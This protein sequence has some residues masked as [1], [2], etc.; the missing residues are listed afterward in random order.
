[1]VFTSLSHDIVAHEV[2]HALL[3]GLRADFDV[4]SGQDVRA[5]HEGFADLVAIFQRFSYT[6]V[7]AAAIDK[8]RGRLEDAE[9][10]TALARQFGQTTGAGRAL[11]SAMES[12]SEARAP[13]TYHEDLEPHQLGLVLVLAIFDAFRTVFRRKTARYF[14]LASNG[15]GEL[16]TGALSPDL[17]AILAEKASQLASQFLNICI[18]AIDY[19]P[20]VDI[21]LGEFL[22]A[23][24]TA[25]H[26]LVPD[27]PWAYR[28]ALIDAF[29]RRGIHPRGVD[30]L[31]EDALRWRAP[32]RPVSAIRE[33]SFAEL[34]FEGDPARPAGVA[35]LQRQAQ[36]LGRTVSRPEYREVFGLATP[37]DLRL[38]GDE[39][40]RP[41]VQSIRS[42]RRVGPDGQIVFDLVAE[43]T[44][45]R[46]VAPGSGAPAFDFIGGSTV[47]IGPTGVIRYVISKTVLNAERLDRQRRYITSAAGHGLW[48]LRGD[49]LVPSPQPFKLLHEARRDRP[50]GAG[51]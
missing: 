13:A 37:G 35:E 30:F 38:G 26:D 18:R 31:S 12:T 29:H 21:E 49:R 43:V 17:Q 9:L 51:A 24:V 34:K 50:A 1:L 28:E 27:D 46:R 14:R 3:D 15:T 33:L 23:I 47:I 39:V 25:D 42:S 16:A 4:P 36:A 41:C 7:V 48:E 20:P 8:A 10:L 6:S 45:R 32:A 44:Q 2:T 22:R 5:F 11:R 40:G 19:C